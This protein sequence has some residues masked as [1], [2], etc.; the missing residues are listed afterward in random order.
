MPF[1]APAY[2]QNKTLMQQFACDIGSVYLIL[3]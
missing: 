2:Q 1:K 3:K